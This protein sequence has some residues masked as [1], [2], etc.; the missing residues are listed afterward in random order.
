MT[1]I[2]LSDI[3]GSQHANDIISAICQGYGNDI[4]QQIEVMG[5]WQELVLRIQ[6][7]NNIIALIKSSSGVEHYSDTAEMFY[8]RVQMFMPLGSNDFA[9]LTNLNAIPLIV[10]CGAGDTSFENRNNTGYGAGLEFWDNDLVQSADPDASSFAN[11]F[12]LGK[13]LKIKD[14]LSCSWWETRYRARVTADRN[15]S[16]REKWFWDLRNGFGMINVPAAIGYQ[17][18]IPNDPF[19]SGQPNGDSFIK[20]VIKEMETDFGIASFSRVRKV[21]L[22]GS[23]ATIDVDTFLNELSYTGSK[24]PM[25]SNTYRLTADSELRNKIYDLLFQEGKPLEKGTIVYES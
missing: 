3:L 5:N 19:Q 1:R 25:V 24:N 4:S 14:A 17:G 11:G 6:S 22:I 13:L 16:N 2:I 20:G 18:E 21:Q 9:E 12:I 15:E 7:D 23:S 8:P 10:T